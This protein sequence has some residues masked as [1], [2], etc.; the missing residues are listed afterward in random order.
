MFTPKEMPAVKTPEQWLVE[1]EALRKAGK[2]AEADAELAKFRQ[3]YP[4][5][6]S[7]SS[8][9]SRPDTVFRPGRLTRAASGGVKY[10][11]AG[12]AIHR[13]II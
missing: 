13:R 1:I 12:L 9:N 3:R 5:Y 6:P 10:P 2:H 8:R 11:L 7:A 4:D